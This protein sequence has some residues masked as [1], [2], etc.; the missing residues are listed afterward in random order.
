M[1]TYVIC[2]ADDSACVGVCG[3]CA[4][5]SSSALNSYALM[6]ST[7]LL[8]RAITYDDACHFLRAGRRRRRSRISRRGSR[9]PNVIRECQCQPLL[10][11]GRKPFHCIRSLF[12]ICLTIALED[13][14]CSQRSN[15]SDGICQCVG[16]VLWHIRRCVMRGAHLTFVHH[17]PFIIII[18][19][20][21]IILIEFEFMVTKYPFVHIVQSAVIAKV[22]FRFVVV[23]RRFFVCAPFCANWFDYNCERLNCQLLC[24]CFWRT[25]IQTPIFD[26]EHMGCNCVW[27]VV[28]M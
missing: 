6:S 14:R 5:I 26:L 22:P 11:C 4:D 9:P 25:E 2:S 15:E 20:I 3:V 28:V 1:Y 16:G 23:S 27:I 21:I 24:V 7:S 10:P 17:T 12:T 19:I 18:I 13:V 8:V